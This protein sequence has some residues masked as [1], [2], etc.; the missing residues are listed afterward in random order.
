MSY[1]LILISFCLRS[2][3]YRCLAEMQIQGVT[4]KM[5]IDDNGAYLTESHFFGH[6][7]VACNMQVSSDIQIQHRMHCNISDLTILM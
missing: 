2:H 3:E 6:L 7:V 1:R 5:S 4:E